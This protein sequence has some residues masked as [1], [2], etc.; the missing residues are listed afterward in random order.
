MSEKKESSKADKEKKDKIR[1]RYRNVDT[2]R[3]NVIPSIPQKDIFKDDE[4]KRVA[5]YARVST[6][7]VQ[8]TSS[9]ELQQNY[10]T[11]MID[12]HEKWRLVGIYADEGISGTSLKN[13]KQFNRM[14]EDCRAGKVDLIVTKSVSRFARNVKDFHQCIEELSLLQPPVGVY[15]ELEDK[16]TL[17]DHDEITLSFLSVHAQQESHTKSNS[18]NR[19]VDMRYQHGMFLTPSLLGYDRDEDGNL[20]VNETEAKTVRLV[21][22]MY[23]HGYTC[24]QIAEKLTAL[25][26]TTK[27]SNT[28]WSP[29]SILNILQ[30]EKPSGA[31]IGRKTYT[32]YYL[33]HKARKNHGQRNKYEEEDHHEKIISREDFIAVQ[34]LISKAKYNDKSFFPELKVIPIGALKGFVSIHLQWP[35]FTVDH[36]RK[37]SDSVYAGTD[38]P[39]PKSMEAKTQPGDF[40]LRGFEVVR[41]QFFNTANKV[42][43]TF[44]ATH[45][46]FSI[47][48]IRKFGRALYVEML[49]HPVERLLVVRACVKD[50]KAAVKWANFEADNYCSRTIRGTVYLDV[51]YDLCGWN[52]KFKYRICGVHREKNGESLIV[53]DLREPEAFIPSSRM[54][55]PLPGA[56]AGNDLSENSGPVAIG[57]NTKTIAFPSTWADEFGSECYYHAQARELASIDCDMRWNVAVEGRPYQD[58]SCSDVTSTD[59]AAERVAQLIR[60]MESENTCNECETQN[61]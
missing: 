54:E 7:S 25:K 59:V 8:Q 36:Y 58:A 10:Y 43:V 57:S 60:E 13:R 6:D 3:I 32:P 52:Q 39:Q 47:E 12:R 31:V 51:I 37:A 33:D 45:L 40:D 44:S 17:N 9:F 14:M 28:K 5:I 41:S 42:C 29:Q 55:S 30:N 50:S 22:Y 24:R 18:M 27:K 11:G 1:V 38:H 56:D 53:F 19:S 21:F 49:L 35:G 46:L 23:L 61:A 15:F 34:C 16:Y 2:G 26:R 48:C 20:V 4:E